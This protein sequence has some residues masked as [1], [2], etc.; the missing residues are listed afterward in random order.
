MNIY[1]E[2]IELFKQNNK[3]VLTHKNCKRIY[4]FITLFYVSQLKFYFLVFI[5]ITRLTCQSSVRAQKCQVLL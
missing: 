4:K 5:G 3:N 1:I 2:F